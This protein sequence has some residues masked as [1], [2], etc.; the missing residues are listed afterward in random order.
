M[1][2]IALYYQHLHPDTLPQPKFTPFRF[3]DV[4]YLKSLHR[5]D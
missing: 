2:L 3:R 1:A 5:S 4:V